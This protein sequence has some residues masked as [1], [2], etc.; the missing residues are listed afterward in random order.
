[1]DSIPDVMKQALDA[2]PGEFGAEMKPSN[3]A[4]DGIQ[5]APSRALLVCHLQKTASKAK[6]SDMRNW[7]ATVVQ[8]S[9]KASEMLRIRL[10]ARTV[11]QNI[12]THCK[13]LLIL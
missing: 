10:V 6:L 11:A 2:I 13:L 3:P 7:R 8:Q 1:V 5:W 4:R 9:W 12:I